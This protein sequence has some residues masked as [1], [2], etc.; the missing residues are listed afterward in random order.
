MHIV[1]VEGFG[2][3]LRFLGSQVRVL[4]WASAR[5]AQ[6]VRAQDKKARARLLPDIEFAKV[7]IYP[8]GV[9]FGYFCHWFESNIGR[10]VD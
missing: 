5:L 10:M 9:A 2:Y 3:F 6:S 7:K 8:R 1:G 4:Q